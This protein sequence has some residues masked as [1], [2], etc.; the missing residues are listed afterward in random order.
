MKINKNRIFSKQYHTGNSLPII[1]IILITLISNFLYYHS[2]GQ[3]IRF[4]KYTTDNGLSQGT[5]TC[6]LQDRAGYLWFGTEDGL[7]RFDGYNFQIFQY[8][9]TDSN[10]I[11]GNK[12]LSLFEDSNGILWIGTNNGLNSYEP[13]FGKITR[14]QHDEKNSGS[15]PDNI[16]QAIA[17]DRQQNIWLGTKN[18]GLVKFE[19]KNKIF[20]VYNQQKDSNLSNIN[21]V[22]CLMIDK[23]G[24]LWVGTN[25]NGLLKFDIQN[26]I[27]EK[28][29]Y[30]EKQSEQWN[31]NKNK[32]TC[33]L[34]ESDGKIWV[35]T[36]AGGIS[37]FDRV[38]CR[39]T[40]YG[41]LKFIPGTKTVMNNLKNRIKTII[42]DRNGKIWAAT[43]S[44][45]TFYD[46]EKDGFYNYLTSNYDD[47][48][49]LNFNDLYSVYE[50]KA[51]SLWVGTYG[52]GINVF[53][54]S[55]WKFNYYPPF[56]T[57]PFIERSRNER[58]FKSKVV[59]AINED[60]DGSLL[61]GTKD[62]SLIYFKRNNDSIINYADM[63]Q[64]HT[65]HP[66]ILA[67]S[68]EKDGT[69]WL[70]TWGGGLQKFDRKNGMVTTYNTTNSGMANNTVVCLYNE[71]KYLWLGTFGGLTRF[72]KS[73]EKFKT[74]TAENGFGS[75]R[76]FCIAGNNNDT[77]LVG[78]MY[79][80]FNIFNTTTGIANAFLNNNKDT[81]SISSN[82]VVHIYDSGNS[83]VWIA[84]ESGLNKF[85]KK[86]RRFISYFRKD[87]LPND[88]I[89]AIIPDNNGCLW[90]STN[91]GISKFAP[92]LPKVTPAS[93]TNY[94]KEYGLQGNEF[95]QC[96]YFKN[97]D[98]EIFF[99]G[100]NGIN[101]FHPDKMEINN[102]DIPVHF[103]VFKM[104]NNEV[105][106]DSVFDY[107]KKIKLSYKENFIAFEFVGLDYV[108][109]LKNLYSYKMENLDIGWSNP[110]IR[111]FAS[112]PNLEPGEYIFKVKAANSEGIWNKLEKQIIIIITPPFYKR[113]SFIL[114]M[115][116]LCIFLLFLFYQIRTGMLKREKRILEQKVAERTY[117]LQQKNED[118]M[119]SIEY[120]RRIQS[121]LLPA[122]DLF[123]EYFSDSFLIY[124]PKTIVSGDFF[125]YA[126]KNGLIYY[127]VAD[128]TGHGV[129]GAFMSIIGENLLRH[130]ITIEEIVNTNDILKKLNLDVKAA[131]HQQGDEDNFDGMDI[132]LC[133]YN[134]KSGILEFSGANR[135]LCYI[136]KGIFTKFDGKKYSIGGALVNIE[137]TFEKYEIKIQSGDI[138]YLF[139]D[140]YHDQYNYITG[141]KFMMK[142]FLNLLIEIHAMHTSRQKELL[143]ETL[144]NW[145]G[146]SEQIDDI[147]VL[148]VRF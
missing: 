137:K 115:I 62:G 47:P 146:E 96:A 92:S 94:D 82:S 89:Y 90:M 130:I 42:K 148:G 70:G 123:H 68:V 11:S 131:L 25:C 120:A 18:C 1:L 46:K 63:P 98:G 67:I 119:S 26:E 144:K 6:I 36:D 35:G 44:G 79:G 21:D 111:R 143:E 97:S 127:T 110:D 135:P 15:I 106:F 91:R 31:A 85:N 39:F 125:W 51:G 84:T 34:E 132:A 121:A 69:I 17:E 32:I 86:T 61:I 16:I 80:G 124:K 30:S 43:S 107:K 141:K 116:V 109:P 27:F 73:T 77:L 19:R 78:T 75:N 41:I 122:F 87:G 134:I 140:G 22:K 112:Y 64:F 114:L 66:S 145:M 99:G 40:D 103:A 128:C 83:T 2:S 60:S 9:P 50:D 10:S 52:N 118:I 101:S 53:H 23:T 29:L 4:E 33:L 49:S 105:H 129:P 56:S 28:Y 108:F 57:I 74:Y 59:H 58:N 133:A 72:E 142:N 3:N 93:F 24:K 45:L 54:P 37:R 13:L 71:E 136:S 14:F 147:I 138:I 81:A 38:S 139:S 20:S 117:E 100:P 48:F 102:Y 12:I 5:I 88:H 113:T 76:I 126:E 104:F 95:N 55:K 65:L 7:N 8:N